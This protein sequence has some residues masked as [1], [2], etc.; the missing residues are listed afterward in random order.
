MDIFFIINNFNFQL[1]RFK[2]IC[3]PKFLTTSNISITKLDLFYHT[4][5]IN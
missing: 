4:N 2:K 3:L 5:V 1:I